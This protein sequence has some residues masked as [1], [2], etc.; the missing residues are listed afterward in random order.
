MF[1]FLQLS[2]PKLRYTVTGKR[3]NRG[4]DFGLEIF[5]KYTLYVHEK[6][7]SRIQEKK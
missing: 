4:A 3:V 7:L 1:K 2:H 5:A 6:A